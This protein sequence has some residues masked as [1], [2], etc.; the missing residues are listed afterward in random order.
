MRKASYSELTRSSLFP[1]PIHSP[2]H[3]QHPSPAGELSGGRS[4]FVPCRSGAGP[5]TPPCPEVLSAFPPPGATPSQPG[6][7]Y[8]GRGPAGVPRVDLT[9]GPPNR[10]S[11][12]HR[13][14][15]NSVDLGG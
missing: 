15:K 1:H 4:G 2:S 10:K 3:A 11:P 9:P 13:Q 7:V 14:R 5:G 8:A 12:G 6:A